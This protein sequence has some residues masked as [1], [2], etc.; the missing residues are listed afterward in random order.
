[1]QQHNRSLFSNG[2]FSFAAAASLRFRCA[3]PFFL[4]LVCCWPSDRLANP[5]IRQLPGLHSWITFFVH[6]FYVKLRSRIPKTYGQITIRQPFV[7]RFSHSVNTVCANIKT[8]QSNQS[9]AATLAPPTGLGL[10]VFLTN[11]SG[12]KTLFF[13]AACAA[14]S[15]FRLVLF[16]SFYRNVQTTAAP[17]SFLDTQIV[18]EVLSL[19]SL[20]RRIEFSPEASWRNLKS[21]L[22]STDLLAPP[23]T[24]THSFFSITT[25]N[26]EL[27]HHILLLWNHTHTHSVLT[28]QTHTSAEAHTAVACLQREMET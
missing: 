13:S 3:K 20:G 27:P 22:F 21:F 26:K 15:T 28:A 10:P 12:W 24:Y 16:Q 11:G 9:D 23:N 17:F 18:G 1:M 4:S 14:R 6:F 19:S 2:P 8:L 25:S 5:Q 7:I